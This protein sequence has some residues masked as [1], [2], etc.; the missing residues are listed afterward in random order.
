MRKNYPSV[1]FDVEKLCRELGV[2]TRQYEANALIHPPNVSE[3]IN[4]RLLIPVKGTDSET[5]VRSL[6]GL[7]CDDAATVLVTQAIWH[8]M[9][10]SLG[11]KADIPGYDAGRIL[12]HSKR[13]RSLNSFSIYAVGHSNDRKPFKVE[14]YCLQTRHRFI[15]DYNHPVDALQSFYSTSQRYAEDG[16]VYVAD[17]KWKI[18]TADCIKEN[19]AL[20]TDAYNNPIHLQN[21]KYSVLRDTVVNE[22]GRRQMS[23]QLQLHVAMDT[24]YG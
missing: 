15:L 19:L 1:G 24:F 14:S 16:I 20:L 6:T 17:P 9:P 18:K 10:E 12:V 23:R 8:T 21:I 3:T 13:R 22:T 7:A 5:Q 2:H 11:Q 4:N